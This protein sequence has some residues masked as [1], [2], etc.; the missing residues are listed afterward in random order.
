MIDGGRQYVRA[1]GPTD[2]YIVK[3]GK[4]VLQI[5]FEEYSSGTN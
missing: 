2:V 1:S 3:D 5:K 4:L